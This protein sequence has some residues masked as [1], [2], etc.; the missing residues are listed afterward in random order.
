M[1]ADYRPD[2][3]ETQDEGVS[4]VVGAIL[5]VAIAVVLAAVILF[6][7]TG[8]ADNPQFASAGVKVS[9]APTGGVSVQVVDMGTAE[10]LLVQC[11]AAEATLSSVGESAVLDA[12]GCERLTVLGTRGDNQQVVQSP[13]IPSNTVSL[14]PNLFPMGVTCDVTVSQTGAISTVADGIAAANP[15]D[16]ICFE[17]TGTGSYTADITITQ[18]V[19]LV[20]E[21]GATLTVPDGGV[22]EFDTA[23]TSTIE[24]ASISGQT[25]ASFED[26]VRTTNGPLN[27]YNTTIEGNGDGRGLNVEY[28]TGT[29]ELRNLSVDGVTVG[30]NVAIASV[31]MSD[32]TVTNADSG[33]YLQGRTMA[34]SSETVTVTRADIQATNIGVHAER[35]TEVVVD[36][37]TIDAGSRAFF[38]ETFFGDYLNNVDVSNTQ[39]SS[40]GPNIVEFLTTAD[41]SVT[42]DFS[43]NWW[44]VDA[45]PKVSPND[46]VGGVGEN[47]VL[48]NTW[49]TDSSCTTYNP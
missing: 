44:G 21:S 3:G 33:L 4:P 48:V 42:V 22:L 19:T 16:T 46:R 24:S 31:D 47:D 29:S 6:F 18:D 10:E 8:L 1:T 30:V 5:M 14:T 12:S 11:G 15:G 45:D 35:N 34:T 39:M 7:V 26:I 49:C 20:T 9:A 37:S 23:G 17:N 38:L 28:A 32:I 27:V 2:G 13:K 41:S 36:D 40:G 43:E 25:T